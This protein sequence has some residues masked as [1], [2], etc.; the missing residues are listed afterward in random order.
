VVQSTLRSA[1]GRKTLIEN[2]ARLTQRQLEAIALD[3]LAPPLLAEL[4]P[5]QHSEPRCHRIDRNGTT[6][7][8]PH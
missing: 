2:I 6:W 5:G 4:S 1:A 3:S 7:F 8:K